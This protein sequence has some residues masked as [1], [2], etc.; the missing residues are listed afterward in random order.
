MLESDMQYCH[1]NTAYMKTFKTVFS[2][3][4]AMAENGLMFMTKIHFILYSNTL[5]KQY[6]IITYKTL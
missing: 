2:L 1:I 3:A 6:S 5:R 4:V